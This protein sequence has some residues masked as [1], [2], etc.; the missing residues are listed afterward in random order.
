MNHFTS[1]EDKLWKNMM[2]TTVGLGA[3][4]SLIYA[5]SWSMH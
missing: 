5:N 3:V 2:L 1:V 4:A